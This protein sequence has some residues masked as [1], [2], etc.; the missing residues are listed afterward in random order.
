MLRILLAMVTLCIG[1]QA[2]M[3][4]TVA[5]ELP[6]DLQFNCTAFD[7]A[8]DK[9][10]LSGRVTYRSATETRITF[11]VNSALATPKSTTQ[12][13][14]VTNERAAVHPDDGSLH[15]ETSAPVSDEY[16]TTYI[17]YDFHFAQRSRLINGYVAIRKTI[18]PRSNV[19]VS[20]LYTATGLC[21]LKPDEKSK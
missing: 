21:S 14:S 3:G 6:P 16:R 19:L 15:L 5:L 11:A 4:E 18:E 20:H 7:M 17:H 1:M 10:I 8:G 9:H 2:A 12:F 13:R